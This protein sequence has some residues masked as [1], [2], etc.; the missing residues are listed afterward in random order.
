MKIKVT[1]IPDPGELYEDTLESAEKVA[2]ITAFELAQEL[3]S[4]GVRGIYNIH[5]GQILR[6][7]LKEFLGFPMDEA[8]QQERKSNE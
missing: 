7:K 5:A 4:F 8:L 2:Q 3:K 1:I 6:R